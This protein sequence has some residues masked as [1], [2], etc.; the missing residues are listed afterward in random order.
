[1]GTRHRQVR[2]IAEEEAV[3]NREIAHSFSKKLIY[4]MASYESRAACDE[5]MLAYDLP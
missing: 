1:V 4:E 2:F 3:N 5:H